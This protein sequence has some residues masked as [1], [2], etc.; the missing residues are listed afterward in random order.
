MTS[1]LT[2]STR[3]EALALAQVFIQDNP[4]GSWDITRLHDG[5]YRLDLRDPPRRQPVA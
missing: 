2:F 3:R 5:R 1:L 4:G